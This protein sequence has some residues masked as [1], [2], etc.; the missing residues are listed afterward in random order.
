M[1]I[2]VNYKIVKKFISHSYV[3]L[4]MFMNKIEGCTYNCIQ[5]S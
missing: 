5:P 1:I 2:T 4:V 3:L